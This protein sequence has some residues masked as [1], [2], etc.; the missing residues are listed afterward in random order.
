MRNKRDSTRLW[1]FGSI[2]L[3]VAVLAVVL[4]T[5][6]SSADATATE[7]AVDT[8]TPPPTEQSNTPSAEEGAKMQATQADTV[9]VTISSGSI[10]VPETVAANAAA[11][12]VTNSGQASHGFAIGTD[13][14]SSPVASI[15]NRLETGQSETVTVQ[16]QPGSYVAYCPV[17]GHQESAEFVVE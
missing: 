13:L 11:F 4:G 12:E 10:N 3:G 2:A 7:R 9:V 1:I 16:L 8:K 5:V 14:S 15:D 6:L 17:E